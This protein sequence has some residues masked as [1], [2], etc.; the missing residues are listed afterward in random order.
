MQHGHHLLSALVMMMFASSKS[1]SP[2]TIRL[3]PADSLPDGPMASL[4][5]SMWSL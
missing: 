5:C 2:Q 4:P 1:V 3:D